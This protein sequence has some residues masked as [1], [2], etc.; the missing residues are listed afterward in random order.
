MEEKE[1]NEVEETTSNEVE[2]EVNVPKKK[3]PILPIV[4]GVVVV[5]LLCYFLLSSL[6]VSN[7]KV[8][9]GEV[10]ALFKEA[11]KSVELANKNVLPYDLEKDALGVKGTISVKSDYKG[12]GVDLSKLEN[13]KITYNGVF[14]KKDNKASAE[15]TLNDKKAILDL[16]TYIKGKNV[17]FDLGDLYNKRIST[18]LDKEIKDL[19]TTKSLNI[20]DLEKII[21]KTEKVTLDY[22]NKDN[23]TSEKVEKEINGKKAKY[24]KVS[25]KIDVNDYSKELLTAYKEDEEIVEILANVSNKDKSDIKDELGDSISDLKEADSETMVVDLYLKGK[26][27]KEVVIHEDG[28]DDIGLIIDIDGNLYKFS[29]KENADEELFSGE[30]NK[31]DRIFTLEAK[32]NDSKFNV[33]LDVK[34]DNKITGTFRIKSDEVNVKANLDWKTKVK[35]KSQTTDLVV[36]LDMEFGEE[37]LKATITNSNDIIRNAK[38]E[39]INDKTPVRYDTITEDELMS[40]YS[41]FM[42]KMQPIINEIAPSM[43]SSSLF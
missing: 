19:E 35:K 16:K 29:F 4:A 12:N 34:S 32:E 14:D 2:K 40:I 21:V 15:I 3:S 36:D 18:E 41:K 20:D 37:S 13:Y 33:E 1:Q 10:K 28:E 5:C 11:K 22:V 30:Y 9:K 27:A 23:I 26:K 6:L 43:N 25:Y 8:V 42:E 24:K 38:V 7:V 31:K 17:L 39:E